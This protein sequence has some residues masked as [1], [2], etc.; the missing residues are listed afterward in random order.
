MIVEPPT[1]RISSRRIITLCLVLSLAPSAC[2]LSPDDRYVWLESPVPFFV[3]ATS[4][5]DQAVDVP[6][7]QPIT[8]WL[9]TYLDP[10]SFEYFNALLMES[11]GIRGRGFTRY[12][13]WDRSL[14]IFPT[15]NLLPNLTYTLTVNPDTVR[16]INGE[17]LAIPFE[18]TFRTASTETVDQDRNLSRLSYAEHV[19]PIIEAHC[20]C[21]TA[22][23]A[24]IPLDYD[25]LLSLSSQSM[26]ARP[27]VRPYSP[28]S[29]YLMEK[30][31]PD[32]PDRKWTIMP[33]PQSAEEP[34]EPTEIQVIEQWIS[35][36]AM[37]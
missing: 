12:Q 34:L 24:Q 35:T 3:E 37:P 1:L 36:G 7:N 18:L 22:S 21:H 10:D 26:A 13:L 2:D 28:T 27:F 33:P 6:L 30:I 32:Y 16:A 11:G 29:S 31:L 19:A 25:R 23:D 20:S 4:L 14:T 5:E 15:A 9:S 8:L 17:E